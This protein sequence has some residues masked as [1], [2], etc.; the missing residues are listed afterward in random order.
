MPDE[1]TQQ[2]SPY[3]ACMNGTQT[4]PSRCVALEGE[5]G[6]RVGCTIYENRPSPCREFNVHGEN[7]VSNEDCNRARAHFGLP[8]LADPQIINIDN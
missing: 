4:K 2:M 6:E 8:P 1:L 5:I 3:R 7:G